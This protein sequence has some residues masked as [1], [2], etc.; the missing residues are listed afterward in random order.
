MD[1]DSRLNPRSKPMEKIAKPRKGKNGNEREGITNLVL[2]LELIDEVVDQTVVEILT[3]QV[4]VTGSRLDLEDTLL[5]GQERNIEGT[6][7]EIEDEDVA[8]TLDLLIETVGNGSGGRLV[9][10]SENVEASNETGILGSLTLRVVEVGRD[11][12]DSVVDGLTEVRLGGL[13]HLGEDHGGDLLGGEGLL[14]ALE[15]NLD[16]R[17]A[18]L[19]DDLE[20]E[21]LHIG[22]DLRVGELATDQT[23]GIED[24]VR[25]VHGNLVLGGIT[26][27]TLGVG[28]TDERGSGS[29]TLVVGDNVA[30]GR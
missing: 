12:D 17:L 10:D 16:D 4:S 26:D 25:G 21:V 1:S 14:L 8:L 19:V 6:T 15:L 13:T 11:G 5:N 18:T 27:Q 30:S 24:S 3:T 9:D 22:L 7:T 20:G 23:L 29:V 28:E 2:A